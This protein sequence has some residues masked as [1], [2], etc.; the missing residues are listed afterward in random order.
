MKKEQ[1]AYTITDCSFIAAASIS[2]E[3]AEALSRLADASLAHAQAISAIANAL[4]GVSGHIDTGI[5]IGPQE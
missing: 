1:P 5:R 2:P 4:K 3:A